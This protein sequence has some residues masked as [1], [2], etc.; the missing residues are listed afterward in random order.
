MTWLSL[1]SE[2]RTAPNWIEE[3]VWRSLLTLQKSI[4]LQRRWQQREEDVRSALVRLNE[5]RH[6]QTTNDAR[7]LGGKMTVCDLIS[8][9]CL[10]ISSWWWMRRHE[11][12]LTCAL[13]YTVIGPISPWPSRGEADGD[14]W[15]I[16]IKNGLLATKSNPVN[17]S[18][19]RVEHGSERQWRSMKAD[20]QGHSHKT[21]LHFSPQSTLDGF[22]HNEIKWMNESVF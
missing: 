10:V 9:F 18:T 20:Q 22:F 5:A 7:V 8:S 3:E 11:V 12:L 1:L 2:T 19:T 14:N 6:K 13:F 17:K 15:W 16:D 21:H 4:R